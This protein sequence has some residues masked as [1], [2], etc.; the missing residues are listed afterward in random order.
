MKLF[1]E[2]MLY[3]LLGV[4]AQNMV[5]TR[6]VGSN[7]ILR[8]AKRPRDIL[9]SSGLITGFTLLCAVVS[10]PLQKLFA[11]Y[12]WTLALQVLFYAAADCIFYCAGVALLKT[13]WKRWEERAMPVL[14]TSAF[15]CV[16]LSVP[17]IGQQSALSLERLVG[18]SIGTGIGF[19]LAVLLVK[20]A[21]SRLDNPDMPE[22]FLGLPGVFLYLGILSM[23]FIGFRF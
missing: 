9:L 13:V 19:L 17:L 11:M 2:M 16:V 23:A 22:G 1:T 7:R 8:L 6:A 5:F 10:Y 18:Y 21:V 14:A 20:D 12:P 3:A 4:F 15:N